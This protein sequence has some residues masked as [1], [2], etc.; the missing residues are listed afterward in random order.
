MRRTYLVLLMLAA[1]AGP[2]TDNTSNTVDARN[3]GAPPMAPVNYL[4]EMSNLNAEFLADLSWFPELFSAENPEPT[5]DAENTEFLRGF[6]R[7]VLEMGLS[8]VGSLD[9]LAAPE[10]LGGVHHAHVEALRMLFNELQ[11]RLETIE[12]LEDLSAVLSPFFSESPTFQPPFDQLFEEWAASCRAL[13]EAAADEGYELVMNCPQL[14][15]ETTGVDVAVSIGDSWT[16]TPEILPSGHIDVRLTV[17]N[18]G[19]EAV[20][21]VVVAIF[22]GDPLALPIRNGRVDITRSML[23]DPESPYAHFGVIYP[24]ELLVA[25]GAAIADAPALEPGESFEI[26]SSGPSGSWVIFDYRP[27]EFKAGTYVVIRGG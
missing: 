21:P 11:A 27:D 6:G 25:G 2:T 18:T 22:E 1:C 13:E 12:D 19:S 10:S 17:T 4:V 14:P 20:Y 15:T 23:L 26:G 16:A 3:P 24:E 7:G 8:H 5:N 9:E